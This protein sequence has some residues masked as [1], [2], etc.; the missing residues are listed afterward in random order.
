MNRCVFAL[1][2]ALAA[3]SASSEDAYIYWMY[4]GEASAESVAP[5]DGGNAKST[6]NAPA[7]P[8][9]AE[10]GGAVMGA[11]AGELK[12]KAVLDAVYRQQP[13]AFFY[14]V[15]L[16]NDKGD[17]PC[18]ADHGPAR[19]NAPEGSGDDVPSVDPGILSALAGPAPWGVEGFRPRTDP[20]P[21]SGMMFLSGGALR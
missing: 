6:E 20:E 10:A 18:R 5:A 19:R 7:S 21:V 2:F 17:P 11:S 16:M 13:Y 3:S 14:C 12:S 15:E 8:A 1:A 9:P 4:G